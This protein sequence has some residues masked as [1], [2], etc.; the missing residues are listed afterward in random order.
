MNLLLV[1]QQTG[2]RAVFL[3]FQEPQSERLR[4][5]ATATLLLSEK[6]KDGKT[7]MGQHC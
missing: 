3:Q 1:P 5:D 2:F 6:E 7:G 4:A